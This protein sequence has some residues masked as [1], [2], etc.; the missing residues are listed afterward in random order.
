MSLEITVPECPTFQGALH[1]HYL[2]MVRKPTPRDI[3]SAVIFVS[4]FFV[5]WLVDQ[6]NVHI[7]RKIMCFSKAGSGMRYLDQRISSSLIGG[8][9]NQLLTSSVITLLSITIHFQRTKERN[10]SPLQRGLLYK[11][12]SN[13]HVK[14]NQSKMTTAMTQHES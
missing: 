7:H 5:V 4:N 2:G 1:F 8:T 9:F 10:V 11:V 14:I 12:Q 3:W 13:I 6:L